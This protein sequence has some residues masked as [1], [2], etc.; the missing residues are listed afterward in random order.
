M[1]NNQ[2]D[3][4]LFYRLK[5]GDKG[6]LEVVFLKYYDP[7]FAFAKSF[8]N[9]NDAEEV[10]SDIFF[11]LWQKKEIIKIDVSLKGYLYAAVRNRCLN[12]IERNNKK[13]ERLDQVEYQLS[14]KLDVQPDQLMMYREI[15]NELDFLIDQL[16]SQ[17]KVIFKLSRDEEL[18][19]K[20][21]SKIMEISVNTVNTQIYRA[22]KY[23]RSKLFTEV[24]EKL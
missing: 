17:C 15:Q 16:P 20:E 7:L 23:L 5:N 21:I 24:S 12:H 3:I 1:V 19:H 6:A 2:A 11:Q 14:E 22:L 4:D 9:P 8:L 10:V 18:S 13:N